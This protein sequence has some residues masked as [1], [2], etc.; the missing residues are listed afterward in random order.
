MKTGTLNSAVHKQVIGSDCCRSRNQLASFCNSALASTGNST[1]K[2]SPDL[3]SQRIPG[4]VM[5]RIQWPF[6]PCGTKFFLASQSHPQRT[7]SCQSPKLTTF[8]HT[9]CGTGRRKSYEFKGLFRTNAHRC[10]GEQNSKKDAVKKNG[11]NL[12]L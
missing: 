10:C 4:Q 6:W 8:R 2:N 5:G 7:L 9:R 1:L 11:L 12:K 3:S